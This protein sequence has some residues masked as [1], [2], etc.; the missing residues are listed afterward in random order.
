[1]SKYEVIL[2]VCEME[3]ISKAAL[4]L[5]YSQSAVSQAIKNFERELGCPLFKRSK[6]GVSVLPGMERIVQS[7]RVI[8]GEE[9][10]IREAADAVTGFEYGVVRIGSISSIVTR[11]LP[12]IIAAFSALYPQIKFELYVGTFYDLKD[13]LQNE[14]IDFAFTSR[15]GAGDFEFT[16]LLQDELMVLLP[17][18]HPLA[19]NITIS[20][21]ELK[22]QT[23]IISSEGLDHE[24]GEIIK[25]NQV[26]QEE[27]KY[28][29]NEDFATMKLV[30]SGFGV[31][32][33]PKLFLDANHA[34][35]CIR[36][37]KERY[38]RSLGIACFKRENISSIAG[39]FMQFATEWMEEHCL[40]E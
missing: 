16:P 32:I 20:I 8:V 31:S 2:T 37:L 3:N 14:K 39:K 36:P 22:D 15:M 28:I 7:L 21:E 19:K 5:K 12:Q 11:W 38:Y 29:I 30:E 34:D 24:I 4:K 13:M 10:R 23:I 9:K 35:I 27:Y 25:S 26:D 40:E 17:L 18:R 1:M 6:S 33:L